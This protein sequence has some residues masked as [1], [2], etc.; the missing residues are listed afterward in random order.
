MNYS[1]L[2]G[3]ITLNFSS[4]TQNDSVICSQDM[5]FEMA[6]R[7]PQQFFWLIIFSMVFLLAYIYLPKFVNLKVGEVDSTEFLKN[8]MVVGA[9]AMLGVAVVLALPLVFELSKAFWD[10]LKLVVGVG[11]LVLFLLLV[12]VFWRKAKSNVDSSL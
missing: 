3:N 12:W 7:F 6:Q 2:P 8:S 5:I 11:V 10:G 9:L 4:L 1:S